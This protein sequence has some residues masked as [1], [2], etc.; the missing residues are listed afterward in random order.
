MIQ[1]WEN[2]VTDGQMVRQT[3]ESG[4]IVR[5]PT[6]IERPKSESVT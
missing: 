4:L 2:L 6:T 5:C 3:K 1:S